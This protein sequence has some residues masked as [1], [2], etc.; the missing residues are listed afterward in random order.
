MTEF[1]YKPRKN[2]LRMLEDLKKSIVERRHFVAEAPTGFGK[3]VVV[4]SALKSVGA[5]KIIYLTRT[6]SQQRTVIKESR[7]LG[8]K[9]IAVQGRVH[10]CPIARKSEELRKGDSEELSKLCTTLK[11]NNDCEYSTEF[12]GEIFNAYPEEFYDELTSEGVCPYMAM[13]SML[14]SA[15]IAVAPYTFYLNPFIRRKFMEWLSHPKPIIVVDEA[16]NFPEVARDSLTVEISRRSVLSAEK[17]AVELGDP[18]LCEEYHASDFLEIIA[19]MLDE[20]SEERAL[21]PYEFESTV[22]QRLKV[23]LEKYRDMLRRGIEIGE[24]LRSEKARKRKLPRSFLYRV[25]VNLLYMS[26][27]REN[28]IKIASGGRNP[29]ITMYPLD[30]SPLTVD[31]RATVSVHIS[32]TLYPLDYYRDVISLPV[33]TFMKIYPSP[34]PRENL[35]VLYAEDVTSKYEFRNKETYRRMAEYIE[36][37]ISLGK[38]VAIFFPS[39]KFMGEVLKYVDDEI[40][41]E[42]SEDSNILLSRFI[43]YGGVIAG[44]LGGRFSEGIDLPGKLLEIVIIAGLPYPQPTV[45]RKALMNYFDNILG[46]GWEYVFEVPAIRKTVQAIGRLIRSEKD[47]GVAVIL[48]KRAFRLGNYY[49]NFK[50]CS[51][52]QKII[53]EV[54]RFFNDFS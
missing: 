49:K 27:E 33:S 48:D 34:F 14:S 17:E 13:K 26:E 31:L 23:S 25:S 22:T 36:K 47:R 4:L 54:R 32:G 10:Y 18:M 43:R 42:G 29:K 28:T 44:V 39:Y 3:T 2:Q 52:P 6:L 7:V 24:E 46:K 15:N 51:N 21:Q 30:I 53:E 37:I 38:N 19:E 16:H 9:A 45:Y 50:R 8:L 11:K 1:P 40:I 35:L 5:E 41:V 20:F 12:R